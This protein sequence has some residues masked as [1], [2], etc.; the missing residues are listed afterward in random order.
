[1]GI[2][3]KTF[4]PQIFNNNHSAMQFQ[5]TLSSLVPVLENAMYCNT[6]PSY[7]SIPLITIYHSPV[8]ALGTLSQIEH[9]VLSVCHLMHSKFFHTESLCTLWCE[10]SWAGFLFY[11]KYHRIKI[12]QNRELNSDATTT[13]LVDYLFR[14]TSLSHRWLC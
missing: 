5:C 1:M 13:V 7:I 9:T 8:D 2:K 14:L 11:M 6:F 3:P 10:L 4:G 12:L